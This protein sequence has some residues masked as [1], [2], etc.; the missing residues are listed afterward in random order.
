MDLKGVNSRG[1][2]EAKVQVQGH[3][4]PEPLRDLDEISTG[5]PV[6]N[7]RYLCAEGMRLGAG[8]RESNTRE[9][10]GGRP[11]FEESQPPKGE[12]RKVE[13]AVAV[14]VDRRRGSPVMVVVEAEDVGALDEALIRAIR[15]VEEPI[16]FVSTERPPEFARLL[17]DDDLEGCLLFERFG[18]GDN[19]SPKERSKVRGFRILVAGVAIGD[20]D[21]LVTVVVQVIEGTGPG[22]SGFVDAKGH[23]TVPPFSSARTPP[24]EL[25][26]LRDPLETSVHLVAD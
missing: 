14:D 2:P 26:A 17:G 15:V 3:L 12:Q 16:P 21:L 23:A 6:G 19:L 5:D 7:E 8:C 22:P 13:V 25:I 18:V 4:D 11:V 10:P 1:R 24:K 9:A 20:K